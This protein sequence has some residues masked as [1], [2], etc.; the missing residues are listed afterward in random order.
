MTESSSRS[1]SAVRKSFA[2]KL[3]DPTQRQAG[4]P[5]SGI[6]WKTGCAVLRKAGQNSL[7]N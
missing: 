6:L 1:F 4:A 5:H 2:A 7:G 3:R